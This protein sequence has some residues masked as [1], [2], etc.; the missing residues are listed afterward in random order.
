LLQLP[1]GID[2]M[3]PVP[4]E[5]PEELADALRLADEKLALLGL[6]FCKPLL[7]A[8]LAA[9]LPPAERL[10]RARRR[11]L[12]AIRRCLPRW[13]RGLH[14]RQRPLLSTAGCSC[15]LRLPHCCRGDG[16]A[17]NDE[18]DARVARDLRSATDIRPPS[19]VP[20]AAL[21]CRGLR[22][23]ARSRSC[24]LPLLAGWPPPLASSGRR[25]RSQLGQSTK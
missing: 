13:L 14:C 25:G 8:L 24:W 19:L 17:M 6:K 16:D 5:L 9:K 22:R 11:A 3:H 10:R 12:H 7:A 15:W 4:P 20:S 21:R 18:L 2:Q 23:P 1:N